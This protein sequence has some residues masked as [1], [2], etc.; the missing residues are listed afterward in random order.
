MCF[1]ASRVLLSSSRNTKKNIDSY[2]FVT[3][4]WFLS[5]KND[6]KVPLKS[7]K[8]KNLVDV[9]KVT[10]ENSR[11]RIRTKISWIR[12]T[13][14]NEICLFR[15]FFLQESTYLNIIV[16]QNDKD[17]AMKKF[18]N[19]NNYLVNFQGFLAVVHVPVH[20]QIINIEER[21]RAERGEPMSLYK[22]EEGPNKTT[23]KN[24]CLFL[25]IPLTIPTSQISTSQWYPL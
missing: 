20:L 24:C 17:E 23:S 11:I 19:E 9:L 13:A 6:V 10:D 12:N 16:Y 4:L 18:W 25:F 7:N 8:Q 22:R 21:R 5:L 14:P 1:W 15:I 3:S 2:C